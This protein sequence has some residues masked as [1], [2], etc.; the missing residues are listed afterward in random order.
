[1]RIL[2]VTDSHLAPSVPPCNANWRAAKAFARDAGADLTIHL[3]DITLDGTEEPAQHDWAL[4]ESADW[5]TTL[6]FLPGNHDIGDNPPGPGL[7]AKQPLRLDQ[8]AAYRRSYGSDYWAIDAAPWLL[9]GLDAQL[10][11]SDTAA[12]AEQWA[13]L[14]ARLAE[15]RGRPI[16]LLLHKPL[17]L[18]DP[19]DATP[20]IRY[21]P[22]APR[23]RLLELLASCDVRLVLSGHAH[24]YLDRILAGTRHVW[25]PSTAFIIPDE[26]QERIGEKRT[27]LAVLELAPDG[28]GFALASPAGMAQHRLSD[29][30]FDAVRKPR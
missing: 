30:A 12:E 7:P 5:P 27:G 1:M 25:L 17:Y 6:R 19:A 28:F 20:H 15:A 3:G 18:D 8:L 26:M 22:L 13:W 10:F 16:A 2:L 9:V 4:A 29:P 23:R 21:V 11:A 24:Q 14:S